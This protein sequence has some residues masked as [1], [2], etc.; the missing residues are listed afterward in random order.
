M[1]LIPK[2]TIC[3]ETRIDL[4]GWVSAFA[5]ENQAYDSDEDKMRLAIELARQNVLRGTGGPF[6]AAVFENTSGRLVSVGVNSVERLANSA[7]HAEMIALMLAEARA[8]SYTLRAPGM[9]AHV[10]ATSCEPCAMCLGGA[11]WSGVCRVLCGAG[12]ADAE[13]LGFDEGPV[14]PESYRYLND[15]G[16]E[17]VHEILGAEA[18]SIFEL[19]R[20]HGG[21]IYRG[22]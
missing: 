5:D 4:P 22:V 6:G 8:G 9:A 14:F 7:L 3:L 18:R 19:Y 11:F 16:I 17:I 12:R 1:K 15:R 20:R 13:R 21:L 10:L 2:N